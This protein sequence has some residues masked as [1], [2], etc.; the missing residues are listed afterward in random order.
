MGPP[1]RDAAAWGDSAQAKA[2]PPTLPLPQ[3][4]VMPAAR[5]VPS[6]R[7]APN[8]PIS[9]RRPQTVRPRQNYL[10]PPPQL[11]NRPRKD[12]FYTI[13]PSCRRPRNATAHTKRTTACVELTGSPSLVAVAIHS[14]HPTSTLSIPT[15]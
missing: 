12:I 1:E 9:T 15:I 5:S 4:D 13:I 6:P 3:A 14:V 7:R 11:P 10:M 8:T 2:F